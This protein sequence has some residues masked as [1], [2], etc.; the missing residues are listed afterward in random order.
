M[1]VATQALL[2][3]DTLSLTALGRHVK[4]TTTSKHSI[5]RIDRLLGNSA[6]WQE[7]LAVYQWHAGY[8]CGFHPM[9]VVLVDWSDVREQLRIMTLR[10][11]VCLHGRAI[12]LYER[13]FAF[14]H[15]NSPASH[16]AFL[17]ELAQVLP[18]GCTPLILTDAGFRNTWFRQVQAKGW[19]WL[20]R[21]RGDV[22]WTHVGKSNW[23]PI[24]VLFGGANAKKRYVGEVELSRKSSLRCHF[25]LY[26][27]PNKQRK[28]QRSVRVHKHH[29]AQSTHSK[30]A[31]EP[32]L[33]ATNI[34]PHYLSST[35]VVKL[36]SKRMQIEEAF[37]DLKSP[38]YGQGLRCSGSRDP[39]RLDILL[40][41]A[42]LAQFLLWI[43]GLAA[44]AHQWQR[45]YQA[46][47][48]KSRSVL[49]TIRLGKEVR[50][51]PIQP[52]QY[53]ELVSA[54]RQLSYLAHTSGITKL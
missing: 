8:L 36:Y 6:L 46:N 10:A 28:G 17:D 9:P 20:G 19:F 31:T 24:K 13:C 23:L 26:K 32:W 5:K 49:S 15:Y 38:A 41:I 29:C 2:D 35:Q 34:P 51:R 16:Q 39:K 4:A 18:T 37:R 44:K 53:K 54:L 1:V 25:H 7:R 42:L 11:S 48:V 40:L 43:I 47:T 45:H 3:G 33:L 14:E 30:A 52:L 12:T 27:S 50:R 22:T 21:V